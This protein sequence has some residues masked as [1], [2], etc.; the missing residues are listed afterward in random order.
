[1]PRGEARIRT[2]LSAAHSTEDVERVVAGFEAVSGFTRLFI[3]EGR[4]APSVLDRPQPLLELFGG[5]LAAGV[6]GFEDFD[7]I[8][9]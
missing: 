7:G 8:L 3:D 5:E 1:V 6:A 2:Q 4:S 9:G